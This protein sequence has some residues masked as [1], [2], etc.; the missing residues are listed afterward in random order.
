MINN[1]VKKQTSMVVRRRKITFNAEESYK[2]SSTSSEI[3]SSLPQNKLV[4]I[5][6]T[7]SLFSESLSSNDEQVGS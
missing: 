4:G 2:P 3:Q 5:A 7:D 1:H 6:E